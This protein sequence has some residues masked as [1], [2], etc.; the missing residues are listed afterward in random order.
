MNP[1]SVTVRVFPV[2]DAAGNTDLLRQI[3]IRFPRRCDVYIGV[4]YIEGVSDED[5]GCGTCSEGL[6]IN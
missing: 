3:L 6:K 4:D 2:T 5:G 1:G